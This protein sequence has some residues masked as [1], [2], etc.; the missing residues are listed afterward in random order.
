MQE[1][2]GWTGKMLR[3]NLSNH[4]AAELSSMTYASRFIGGRGLASRMYWDELNPP[5]Q[6]F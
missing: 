3:I 2:F 6:R 4:S 1:L 5:G